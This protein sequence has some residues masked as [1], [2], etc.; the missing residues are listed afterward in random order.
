M[1][2]GGQ[3]IA[4]G[5]L[6][7]PD[8]GKYGKSKSQVEDECMRLAAELAPMCKILGMIHGRCKAEIDNMGELIVPHLAPYKDI[9]LDIED[10]T[11][12]WEEWSE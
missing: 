12:Q 2:K 8:T 11:K 7:K 3:L 10:L 6:K 5:K 1:K 9:L 4:L